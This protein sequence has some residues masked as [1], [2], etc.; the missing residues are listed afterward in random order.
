MSTTSPPIEA[1]SNELLGANVLDIEVLERAVRVHLLVKRSVK[2]LFLI[3]RRLTAQ[4]ASSEQIRA[5]LEDLVIEPLILRPASELET[6]K[7]ID[8]LRA[9]LA[10]VAVIHEGALPTVPRVIEPIELHSYLR[11]SAGDAPK[12][13]ETALVFGTELLG[14]QVYP[15]SLAGLLEQVSKRQS[16][17]ATAK[18]DATALK[19]LAEKLLSPESPSYISVQ[20]KERN[21]YI[22]IPAIDINNPLRWPS[23][24]HELGHHDLLQ[25]SETEQSLFNRFELFIGGNSLNTATF[26]EVC[27]EA[28]TLG[29]DDFILDKEN[30]TTRDDD[31][32]AIG[33]RI[34]ESWLQECWCDA[35]GVR[36][37]GL[38]FLYSQLHD[39]MFCFKTYLNQPLKPSQLYPPA[40]FRLRLAKNLVIERLAHSASGNEPSITNQLIEDYKAEE[41][42]FSRLAGKKTFDPDAAKVSPLLASIHSH[43]LAFLKKE[44]KITESATFGGDIST[45]VF[46]QLEVDLKDGLPIPAIPD[47]SGG[48]VRA[49]AAA[50]I[51]LAGWRHRN[52]ALR[53]DLID[54]LK[55]TR[56]LIEAGS[57]V[58][59]AMG[60]LIDDVG[61]LLERSDESIKRSIQVAEWFSLLHDPSPSESLLATDS[62]ANDGQNTTPLPS[63]LTDGEINAL[64]QD[65]SKSGLRVIPLIN[66]TEQVKGSVIDVR[67]GHNFEVF[68]SL[69]ESSID[70]CNSATDK[71]VDSFDVEIDRLDGL[72]ILPGQFVL[73]HTLEYLKLPANVAA[74]IEG[75]SSFARLGIQVHMTAN[76][77]E[78]GFD[79]CLTLEILNSGPSTVV[80]YPG[81]RIAQLRFFRLAQP[82]LKTYGRPTNKYR[83]QLSQNKTKQFTDSEV[84]I[85]RREKTK[86]REGYI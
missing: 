15:N 8:E 40:D 77:V 69:V 82:A 60:I 41:A 7:R 56:I 61:V 19:D 50:E 42:L 2:H 24:W 74:Q 30:S 13:N 26:K 55:K 52:K 75:R 29:M 14:T 73:G 67:L 43:F 51:G 44:I 18:H 65:Q 5:L 27:K 53:D 39:F 83:G 76:L 1:V 78:A 48:A 57:P 64:L 47:M 63:L 59:E 37:A 79:G 25:K 72:Q 54:R 21:A 22:S 81:M 85:F 35:Y 36:K 66:R 84:N 68:Q 6:D 34:L 9:L 58:K 20:K 3:A 32:I 10:T 80:L 62:S 11:Q 23:L 31:L 16:L 70:V 49:A 33:K 46:A 17:I 28:A 71:R 86:I 45:Q 4:S 38:A 12:R